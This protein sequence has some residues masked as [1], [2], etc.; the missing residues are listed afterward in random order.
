MAGWFF[1]PRRGVCFSVLD[2]FSRTRH[3]YRDE[4][5]PVMEFTARRRLDILASLVAGKKVLD[6]GCVDHD[7]DGRQ[8][9]SATLPH[10]R[11]ARASSSV[12]GLDY[13]EE[14]VREMRRMGFD[15]VCG[16]AED[17]D[18][19]ETFDAIVAGEVLEHLTNHRGVLDSARRHLNDGGELIITVPNCGGFFYFA[20]TLLF[21]HETDSWD[22]TCMFTPVTISVLL[23]KCGFRAKR[24]LL[25][26]PPAR[27]YEHK[28]RWMRYAASAG[29]IIYRL[30]CALRMNF[31]RQLIV[32]A[33]P[34]LDETVQ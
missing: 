5:A 25:C 31:A 3:F 21:G 24:I 17:F 7:I 6:I 4:V 27:S 29:N 11:L 15:A 14:G 33:E 32:I 20:C 10:A 9:E 34:Q 2:H 1:T 23:K 19:G 28:S 13:A 26:Q 18:L 8:P 12:K 16:N 30:A 22:H